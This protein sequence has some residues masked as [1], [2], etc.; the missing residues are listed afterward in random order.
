MPSMATVPTWSTVQNISN[1]NVSNL[2][3]VHG[4][5]TVPLGSV[6]L[7]SVPVIYTTEEPTYQTIQITDGESVSLATV[8]FDEAISECLAGSQILES[9]NADG[10]ITVSVKQAMLEDRAQV[11]IYQN[12]VESDP[13][14]QGRENLLEASAE[15]LKQAQE[16]EANR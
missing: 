9:K 12:S 8:R 3:Q 6:P 10:S 14:L 7:S 1:L 4:L 15:I 2:S 16:A 13:V 5:G 11:Y